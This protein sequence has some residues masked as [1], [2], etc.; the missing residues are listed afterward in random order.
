MLWIYKE[1][2]WKCIGNSLIVYW[3]QLNT[4]VFVIGP[5]VVGAWSLAVCGCC[6]QQIGRACSG[7]LSSSLPFQSGEDVWVSGGRGPC[8]EKDRVG[9][10]RR[11]MGHG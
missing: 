6:G 11:P 7:C 1:C 10:Q 2:R 8:L 3:F 9:W 4:F 5:V